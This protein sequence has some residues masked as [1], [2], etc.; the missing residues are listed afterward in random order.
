[1][2]VSTELDVEQTVE[3]IRHLLQQSLSVFCVK[4]KG[5]FMSPVD[6][7]SLSTLVSMCTAV[8]YPE[9][10]GVF[11]TVAKAAYATMPYPAATDVGLSCS[12]LQHELQLNK[13]NRTWKRWLVDN[14]IVLAEVWEPLRLASGAKWLSQESSSPASV[15]PVPTAHQSDPCP[16]SSGQDHPVKDHVLDSHRGRDGT[17]GRA[18]RVRLPTKRE[19]FSV[20]AQC[21]LR[22]VNS[23]LAQ[24]G[25]RDCIP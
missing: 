1:M 21:I 22:A 18:P 17:T 5:H 6:K 11:R 16:L 2:S 15:P 13:F 3:Q 23:D 9:V 10:L 12:Q 4:C 19:D 8:D 24:R 20:L 25:L 7:R 14:R